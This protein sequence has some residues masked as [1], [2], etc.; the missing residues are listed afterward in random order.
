MNIGKIKFSKIMAILLFTALLLIVLSAAILAA[1]W[2]KLPPELP[3]LYSLPW[4]EDQ[5]ITKPWFA[6]GL[7]IL[8]LINLIGALLA[9]IFANKDKVLATVTI[10]A[11]LLIT[12]LYLISFLKVIVTVI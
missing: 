8:V 6:A 3:W 5:L 10:G 2:A 4:G 12:L 7:A 11:D 9:T 1:V